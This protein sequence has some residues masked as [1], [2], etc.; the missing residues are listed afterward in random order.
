MLSWLSDDQMSITARQGPRVFSHPTNWAPNSPLFNAYTQVLPH[1]Y[2]LLT[3]VPDDPCRLRSEWRQ[4]HH[5]HSTQNSDTQNGQS[6]LT[7]NTVPKILSL[8]MA[9]LFSAW[10][11]K[12]SDSGR[13]KRMLISSENLVIIIFLGWCAM[14][15]GE[16]PS[17]GI[18]T[19]GH[20]PELILIQPTGHSKGLSL[21][22]YI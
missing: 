18:R 1:R 11:D 10:L 17:T 6:L 14:S 2:F 20:G 5:G 12:W 16:L 13:L 8:E 3:P 15:S 7:T 9:N 22:A 19:A 4:L 21:N